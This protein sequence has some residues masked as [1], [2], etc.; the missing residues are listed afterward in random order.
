MGNEIL[1]AGWLYQ[2]PFVVNQMCKQQ[3]QQARMA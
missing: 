3:Q 1:L 2:N